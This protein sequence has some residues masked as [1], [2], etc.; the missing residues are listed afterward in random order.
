MS[1]DNDDNSY[2]RFREAFGPLYEVALARA[3]KIAEHDGAVIKSRQVMAAIGACVSIVI[4]AASAQAKVHGENLEKLVEAIKTSDAN[5]RTLEGR[6][7]KLQ[8]EF[9]RKNGRPAN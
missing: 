8:V 1:N 2:E 3:Q 6:I 5:I 7:A 4:Q 9:D